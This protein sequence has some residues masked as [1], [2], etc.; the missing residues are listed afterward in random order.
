VVR[1]GQASSLKKK[2]KGAIARKAV[3]VRNRLE[4]ARKTVVRVA[5]AS[6]LKKKR[7]GA[8]AWKASK[9]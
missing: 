6:S 4:K 9:K 1:V 7:K 8:I 5:Q 2:R 3:Q